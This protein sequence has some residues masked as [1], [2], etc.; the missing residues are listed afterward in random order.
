MNIKKLVVVFAILDSLS[1]S[2]FDVW[3]HYKLRK[4]AKKTEM[5]DII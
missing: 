4:K 5:V 3:A 2:D 1:T